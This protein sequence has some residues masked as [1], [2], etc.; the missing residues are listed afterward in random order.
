MPPISIDPTHAGKVEQA[1]T[2]LAATFS[3]SVLRT[4]AKQIE[5]RRAS[6]DQVHRL[7]MALARYA[8]AP[9]S[10]PEDLRMALAT[11]TDDQ[12]RLFEATIETACRRGID[13]NAWTADDLRGVVAQVVDAV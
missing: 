8:G 10:L 12:R 1:C 13:V 7:L 4:V 5:S 6:T 9:R 3:R 11:L 2:L